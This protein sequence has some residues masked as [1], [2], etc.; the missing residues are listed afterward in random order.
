MKINNIAAINFK[1]KV[2]VIDTFYGTPEDCLAPREVL[3]F[4][5]S[6]EKLRTNKNKDSVEIFFDTGIDNTIGLK[7]KKTKGNK[8]FIGI[9]KINRFYKDITE[10]DILTAYNEALKIADSEF[11]PEKKSAFDEYI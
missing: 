3:I 11:I 4:K 10:Q 2:K 9:Q 7:V 8:R 6:L 5:N 1:S